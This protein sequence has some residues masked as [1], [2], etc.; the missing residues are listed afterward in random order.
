MAR[1]NVDMSRGNFKDI[2]KPKFAVERLAADADVL[3]DTMNVKIGRA[4][5]SEDQCAAYDHVIKWLGDINAR[6]WL[7]LGG[8]AGTGKTT[9]V[10]T[11]AAALVDTHAICFCAYTGKAASVMRRKLKDMGVAGAY[12]GTIHGLIYRAVIHTHDKDHWDYGPCDK[13]EKDC[14]D[15]GKV[16]RWAQRS[17]E[18][19]PGEMIVVDEA[20]MVT[21]DMWAHLLSYRVPVLAVGDHGQLM[22]VG[23]EA[24][25]LMQQPDLVLEKIHR[26][27]EGNPIIK[28][29]HEV[30]QGR[31]LHNYESDDPRIR[32]SPSFA[33][34]AAEVADIGGAINTALS[35]GTPGG[36][37]A[38]LSEMAV[39]CF[40]NK[41]RNRLNSVARDM[42][43]FRGPHPDPTDVVMCLRGARRVIYN[44]QRGIIT[45]IE[46]VHD[47]KHEVMSQILFPDEEMKVTGKVNLHQF[48]QEK[49]FKGPREIPNI[50]NW[51]QVGLLFDYGY[52]L[53]VHKAQGSQYRKAIV[54]L[55]GA[56][57]GM[58]RRDP[59]EYQRWLYTAITRASEELVLVRA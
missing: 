15:V 17:P 25:P 37:S 29:A 24:A 35:L 13:E 46:N 28:L 11:I 38:V 43:G 2:Y 5:L 26:Q 18:E 54:M 45:E 50:S 12:C 40:T 10:G 3:A 7:T 21:Q 55:E 1:V 22:P 4:D 16:V 56:L 19:F 39:L 34:A 20:S 41:L 8:L 59:A 57:R 33:D 44:G 53:T 30:R 32:W 23:G 6:Q 36:A 31:T 42:R 58:H 9:L 47:E 27:A 51:G 48:N 52:A 49:T 14:P